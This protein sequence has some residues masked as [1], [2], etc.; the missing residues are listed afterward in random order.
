MMEEKTVASLP[1]TDLQSAEPA[2]TEP[3]L[4]LLAE[5]V[6]EKAR[7]LVDK[8]HYRPITLQMEDPLF[9]A[10]SKLADADILAAPVLGEANEYCGFI[11]M[12]Q[13][14]N[15]VIELCGCDTNL[16]LGLSKNR[17]FRQTRVSQI[18]GPSP[19]GIPDGSSMFLALELLAITGL[20]RLAVLNVYNNVLSIVTQS[21]LIEWLAENM[22]LMSEAL[23]RTPVSL[24]KPYSWVIAVNE[25][26]P[27]LSAFKIMQKRNVSGIAVLDY[28]DRIVDVISARDLRGLGSSSLSFAGLLSSVKTLKETVRKQYPTQTPAQVQVVT[29]ADTFEDLL[30][31]MATNKVHRVFVVR[32]RESAAPVNTISQTDVLRFV[33]ES[34]LVHPATEPIVPPEAFEVKAD[35]PKK[36]LNLNDEERAARARAWEEKEAKTRA[37]LPPV[38]PAPIQRTLYPQGAPRAWPPG[39]PY[40]A[41]RFRPPAMGA[42]RGQ[43]CPPGCA[44]PI[45]GRTVGI[46]PHIPQNFAPN[47]AP[48]S[49]PRDFNK[50][51]VQSQSTKND[52]EKM[53]ENKQE[54]TKTE[55]PATI[56][57]NS[58]NASPPVSPSKQS[59]G[60]TAALQ[61]GPIPTIIS[62]GRTMLS[63]PNQIQQQQAKS[64]ATPFREKQ[65]VRKLVWT[66]EGNPLADQIADSL[67]SGK[68]VPQP[69]QENKIESSESKDTPLI[70]QPTGEMKE[71]AGNEAQ[72]SSAVKSVTGTVLEAIQRSASP[73][74]SPT[75]EGKKNHVFNTDAAPFKPAPERVPAAGAFTLKEAPKPPSQPSTPVKGPP[76][77][78]K[79]SWLKKT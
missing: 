32:S 38:L 2:E 37:M 45:E 66:K 50:D 7:S 22:H 16:A 21:M 41:W 63:P 56:S 74:S 58:E 28:R 24:L 61:A 17:T 6:S 54:E 9:L 78:K 34:M 11:D 59:Q 10:L 70:L 77:A 30:V 27:V 75:S 4:R 79:Q 33:L 69:D 55:E 15:Y 35:T 13:L 67:A 1:G 71:T 64:K 3:Q 20:Q 72:D 36:N 49:A 31:C 5:L 57:T 8:L 62:T 73:Q 14:V 68:L 29:G 12:M 46:A 43:I 19:P 40:R 18:M 47:A 23:R 52:V 25:D 76:S 44:S 60:S 39:W 51:V 26:Q 53:K 42:G 48:R 65:Q